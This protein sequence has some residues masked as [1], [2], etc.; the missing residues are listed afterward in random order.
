MWCKR[1]SPVP[2]HLAKM[3]APLGAISIENRG[4]KGRPAT[5]PPAARLATAQRPQPRMREISRTYPP[6]LSILYT[7]RWSAKR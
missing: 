5:A 2:P 7:S 4:G 6:W 1:T 3:P